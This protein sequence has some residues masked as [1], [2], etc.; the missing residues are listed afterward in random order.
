SLD[1]RFGYFLTVD[2]RWHRARRHF[3]KKH[4]LLRGSLHNHRPV[5]ASAEGGP[6]AAQ[7]EPKLGRALAMAGE[8]VLGE[9]RAKVCVEHGGGRVGLRAEAGESQR[10]E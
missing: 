5:V 7:V 6:R 9:D 4:A 10:Q 2:G 8:T 1:V 3:L